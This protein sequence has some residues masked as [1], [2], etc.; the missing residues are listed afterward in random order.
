MPMSSRMNAVPV[1]SLIE[2]ERESGVHDRDRKVSESVDE[3]VKNSSTYTLYKEDHTLGNLVRTQLH[4]NS[5]VRFAGYKPDHPTV[6]N[7]F[8]KVQTMPNAETRKPTPASALLRSLQECVFTAQSLETKFQAALEDFET[9]EGIGRQPSPGRRTPSHAMSIGS[10]Q[11][12]HS[13]ASAAG[14]L[15][16]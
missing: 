11:R 16:A 5:R 10:G 9:A 6:H 14:S 1:E 4:T 12:S 3:R 13:R 8:I 7:I 15:A 2:V